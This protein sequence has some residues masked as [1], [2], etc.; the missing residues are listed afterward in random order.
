MQAAPIIPDQNIPTVPFP[1]STG[2]M[3]P[4]YQ[5]IFMVVLSTVAAGF[6]VMALRNWQKTGSPVALLCL[7]GGGLCVFLEPVVD[8]LGL[9]WFW[10][11]GNWTMFETFGRPIPVWMLPVYIFY[12]GG[13]T[14]YTLGRM[15]RGETTGGIWKLWA[16]YCVVNVLLEEP[17]LWFNLYTYYGAQPLQLSKLPLWWPAINGAMPIVAAA[18][19]YKLKP[20][21]QGAKLGLIVLLVPM[22]DGATNAAVGWPVWNA[23]NSTDQ[24]LVTN[25]AAALTWALAAVLI[26]V[27]GLAVGSNSVLIKAGAG[28]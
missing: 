22:A 3:D 19:I 5:M 28:K 1:P 13:Q 4:T 6:I 2:A 16:I 23:V 27:V 11:E 7:I 18:L 9:C 15:E 14:F 17:P 12:V 21:L 24:L 20:A 10:R 26:W 8:V 25:A